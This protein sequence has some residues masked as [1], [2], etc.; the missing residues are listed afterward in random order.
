MYNDKLVNN[1]YIWVLFEIIFGKEKEALNRVIAN[2]V[3]M[4]TVYYSQV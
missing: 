2:I 3:V 4:H 1:V